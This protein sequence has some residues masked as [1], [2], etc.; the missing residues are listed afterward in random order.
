MCIRD[1]IWLVQ[2]INPDDHIFSALMTL[3]IAALKN[4]FKLFTYQLEPSTI[5]DSLNKTDTQLQQVFVFCKLDNLQVIRWS[6]L[7]K[8]F[9]EKERT[10][11]TAFYSFCCEELTGKVLFLCIFLCF[12][13]LWIW[14]HS[15]YQIL[16][17]LKRFTEGKWY[18]AFSLKNISI[19]L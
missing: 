11:K 4:L 14:L 13:P 1:S 17:D 19:K 8:E 18:L 7:L 2:A 9:V 3:W 15:L 12:D 16:T 10:G 6:H 5:S